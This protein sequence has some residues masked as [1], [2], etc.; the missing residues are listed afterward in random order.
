MRCRPHSSRRLKCNVQNP[1]QRLRSYRKTFILRLSLT[2][3]A[4]PDLRLS[5][6][7]W[8]FPPNFQRCFL[9]L[10]QSR[11]LILQIHQQFV[12]LV[13]LAVSTHAIA[14][15]LS[16]PLRTVYKCE[17][18]GKVQYSDSPCAGAQKVDVTSMRRMSM[19]TACEL[20][21]SDARLEAFREQLSVAVLPVTGMNVQ[22]LDQGRA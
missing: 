6:H 22:Q 14:T 21:G 1:K 9:L 3:G 17:V 7:F 19:F 5:S 16:P 12:T 11:H 18:G 13:L 15:N 8:T 4:C 20:T 2:V 10:D